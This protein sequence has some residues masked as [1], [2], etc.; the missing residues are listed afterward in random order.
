MRLHKGAAAAL[1]AVWLSACSGPNADEHFARGKAYADSSQHKEAIV[2]YK[3]A[4]QVDPRR[5]DVLLKLGDAD[6]KVGDLR[7]AIGDYVRAADVLPDSAEAQ[8]KAGGMLLLARQFEDAKVRA[9]KAL[10]IEPQNVDGIILM[11]NALAGLKNLDG[12]IGE[13]QEALAL[14]PAADAA[15]ANLGTIQLLRGQKEAA[16]ATFTKAVASAP[17]SINARMGLANFY[18]ASRRPKEAEEALKAA[19]A[20]DP[21]NLASNRAIG[22][23]YMATGRGAEAEPYFKTIAAAAKTTDTSISLADYYIATKRVDDARTVLKD[24]ARQTDAFAPATTRLAAVEAQQGNRAV[25]ETMVESVLEKQPA[26]M[27]ARLLNMRLKLAANKPDETLKIAEGVI[28]DDPNS[29]AAAEANAVVGAIEASRDRTEQATKA[30]TEALRIEPRSIVAALA[31][32]RLALS[33]LQFDKAETHANQALALQP[34]NPAARAMLVRLDLARGNTT[35]ANSNLAELQKQFPT[36]P[37]V[38]NLV[39]AQHAV[40]G[41]LDAARTTYAKTLELAPGDMEALEGLLG[42]TFGTGRK[43]DA[44]QA[45]EAAIKRSPPSAALYILAGR[46]YVASG[47]PA[48]AEELLKKAIDLDPAKLQAYGLLGQL[49]ISQRRLGD[50][51][52]QYTELT[53]KNPRSVAVSTML[54]M[55]LEAQRDLPAAEAQYQKTLGLDAEAAVAANNLAWLYVS[56]NRNLDQALQLAQTAA[57]QLGELPQVNDTLGWI[58]YRKGMFQPAVKHL[59]KSIQKDAT[60]ASVHYHLG[61]AYAGDGEFEKARKSLQKALSMSTSFDGAD[62]ARKT[63]ASFGK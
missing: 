18:W 14:N 16:E 33:Q 54:G 15:S 48:R 5:G 17:K 8:V 20:L 31:L 2:E 46:A 47:D 51:K 25:A 19:L 62:D 38:L 13:Y 49:Y 43:Q 22:V 30:F 45:V 10:K 3:L 6:I 9:E 60:D 23:F 11:G 53:K 39:A 59:E 7:A 50:A 24:L 34:T 42:T 1:V 44:I 58:Y 29:A 21:A 27:P 57:K 4:L 52:D 63:L 26:Y 40:A 32:S 55:I 56:S 37:T 28:K 12:A 35:R 41:R 61:M 36:S